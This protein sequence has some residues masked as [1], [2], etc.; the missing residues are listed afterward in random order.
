[1]RATDLGFR[2]PRERTPAAYSPQVT[3]DG[4]YLAYS[5]HQIRGG[6]IGTERRF[7]C[8]AKERT[9]VMVGPGSYEPCK[10][11]AGRTAVVYR[12]LHRLQHATGNGYYMVG[13]HMM[14]DSCWDRRKEKDQGACR[15]EAKS[16]FSH[17]IVCDE[18]FPP[19]KRLVFRKTLRG[20]RLSN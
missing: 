14:Y 17:T 16:A 4:R 6:R 7:A 19:S 12:P 5:S 18:D 1:M 8:Y 15:S 3:R 10:P 13:N 9:G 11:P 20:R 2:S